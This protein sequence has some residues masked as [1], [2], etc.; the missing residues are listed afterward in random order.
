MKRNFISVALSMALTL[1]IALLAVTWVT[2][3]RADTAAPAKLAGY[4]QVSGAPLVVTN[5]AGSTARSAAVTT[6]GWRHH[7]YGAYY[8]PYARPYYSYRPVYSYPAYG[9]GYYP[10]GAYYGGFSAPYGA[11]YRP[12]Y[13]GGYN[14]WRGGY[15]GPYFW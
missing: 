14:Y 7:R 10:Y 4:T 1:T 2:T 13:S 3:S 6:V 12:P 5:L 11:Y 8:A 15:P 9:Y